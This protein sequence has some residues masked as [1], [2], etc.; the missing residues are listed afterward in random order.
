MEPYIHVWI[1]HVESRQKSS[2]I[3]FH[4]LTQFFIEAQYTTPTKLKSE[5]IT[6]S[7]WN[8]KRHLTTYSIAKT[9]NV[10]S[11]RP[12]QRIL[13]FVLWYVVYGN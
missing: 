3:N 7:K 1:I 11:D 2:N 5:N 4:E 9:K 12:M 13:Y 6:L 10:N 8:F